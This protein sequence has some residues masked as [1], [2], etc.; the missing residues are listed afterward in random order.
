MALAACSRASSALASTG[1][2]NRG[3]RNGVFVSYS[4]ADESWLRRLQVHVQPLLRDHEVAWWDDTRIAPGSDWRAEIDQALASTKVA[5]LLISAEFLASDFI[6]TDELPRLLDAATRDGAMV[7][8]LIL[9]PSQFENTPS[10]SRFQSVNPPDQPLARLPRWK[11]DDFFVQLAD[12]IKAALGG[13]SDPVG[14]PTVT[15]PTT[16]GGSPTESAIHHRLV[17]ILDQ[18]SFRW[19]TL[20]RVA[21]EAAVTEETAADILRADE[22]VKFGRGTTGATVVR[23]VD[24]SGRSAADARAAPGTGTATA[25]ASGPSEVYATARD[26]GIRDR[27]VQILQQSGYRWRTIGRL[28][29][30][31]AVPEDTV[32]DLLR[33]DERV[34]FG[35]GRDGDTIVGLVDRVGS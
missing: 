34:K 6:A 16:R 21:A 20:A 24:R 4:H 14:D 27:L 28:A 32:V 29:A 30:E 26:R 23:L 12:A 31:A 5:V 19:R 17:Q 25:P 15:P 2:S 13:G 7:L 11:Q 1:M 33:S 8:S 18:S 22:R 3:Q 10:L 35:L 9:R